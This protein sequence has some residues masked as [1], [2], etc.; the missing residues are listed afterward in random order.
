MTLFNFLRLILSASVSPALYSGKI[1]FDKHYCLATNPPFG[2]KIKVNDTSI[3]EHFDLAKMKG[4]NVKSVSYLKKTIPK[5]P[6][7]LFVEQN[8]KLLKLKIN[9]PTMDMT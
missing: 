9:K 3:L 8:I 2:S 4:K 7:I 6:D 1:N 5:S